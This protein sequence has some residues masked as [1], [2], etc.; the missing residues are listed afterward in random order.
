MNENSTQ[1]TALV[2]G[3]SAGIG[4]ALAKQFALHNHNLILAARSADKL[5][6]L[7]SELAADHG[8]EV[9]VISV[10]LAKRN[11][12]KNLAQSIREQGLEVDILVNNAGVMEH[13]RFVDMPMKAQRGLIDLNISGLT[14]LLHELLPAMVA[15]GSGRVLNVASIAAFQPIPSL[16]TYAATKAYVLSLTES[17]AEELSGTGV[18]ITAL[19]PG[20]TATRMLHDVQKDNAALTRI[21]GLLISRVEDV[22]KDGYNAC[23]SGDVICV[24]GPLNLATTIAGRALPRWVVR[25]LSGIFGRL[26]AG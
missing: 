22:A 5:D 10:D 3:A 12:A 13:G 4:E 23:M 11:G 7:A 14:S 6:A 18:S 19:C 1:P 17:L 26:T 8:I 25:R 24:P 2:T 16:A 21:P 15:R 9:Q 20:F